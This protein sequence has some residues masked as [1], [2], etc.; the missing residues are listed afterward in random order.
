MNTILFYGM[1]KHYAQEGRMAERRDK[2]ERHISRCDGYIRT[3][4]VNTG[5][6]KQVT[7]FFL[8]GDSPVSEFYVATFRNTLFH[9]HRR[10]KREE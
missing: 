4:I 5:F 3:Y 8:L 10:S 2:N 6:V 9:V 1:F 7:V